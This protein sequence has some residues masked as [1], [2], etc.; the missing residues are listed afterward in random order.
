MKQ[1]RT[2][3]KELTAMYR[4]VLRHGIL[5]NAIA[6][7]LIATA[8]AMAE[9][10]NV[11][12][13]EL[14]PTGTAGSFKYTGNQNVTWLAENISVTEPGDGRAIE[15]GKNAVYSAT[16]PTLLHLGGDNTNTININTGGD[17]ILVRTKSVVDVRANDTISITSTVN[18][19]AYDG[20]VGYG[21]L[22]VQNSSDPGQT[23]TYATVNL[24][25]NQINL[26]NLNA[27]AIAALSEGRVNINGNAT[28]K[29]KDAI[30]ASGLSVT[31]INAAG[32]KTVK[33]DGDI[34]FRQGPNS[35]APVDATVNV[36]LNGAESYWTGNT[37]LSYEDKPSDDKLQINHGATIKMTDGATWTATEVAESAE[38]GVATNGR[39]YT[40]LKNLDVNSGNV[41]VNRANGIEVENL[42]VGAGGLTINSGDMTV[43]E[44]LKSTGRTNIASG[45]G[46]TVNATKGA[47]FKGSEFSGAGGAIFA[48]TGGSLDID[49]AKFENNT[50]TNGG[51]ITNLGTSELTIDNS[52]FTGNT[53]ATNGGAIQ[54]NATVDA[55]ISNTTFSGN[56]TGKSSTGGSGG[57]I[58]NG[59]G[60][61][62]LTNNTFTGNGK[63][64]DG[65]TET[66][67]TGTG[68][69]I[70][71][72]SG[73]LE[74]SGG[75][76]TD[77]MANKAGAIYVASGSLS[78]DGTEITGNA[79]TGGSGVIWVNG[80]NG[81]TINNATIDNN[82]GIKNDAPIYVVEG[83]GLVP[84][85][86]GATGN[87]G[88]IY[89]S[90]SGK[91][92]TITGGSISQN[93][94]A[95]GGAIY[96][97]KGTLNIDGTTF[98]GNVASGVSKT[99]SVIGGG[100]IRNLDTLNIKDATFT[101]NIAMEKGGAIF[102][103]ASKTITFD[104]SN[105][106][107]GNKSDVTWDEEN[108]NITAST[109]NDIYNNMGT[110]NIISGAGETNTF[111]GGFDGVA[112]SKLYI[113]GAGT[114]NI[115]NTLKKHTVDVN[116]GELHLTNADLTGSTI[117]VASGAI[118]N[119]IDDAIQDLS[120]NITLADGAGIKGDIDWNNGT[121]DKYASAAGTVK[122]YV[123]NLLNG[124]IGT[125]EKA[126]QV[127]SDGTTVDIAEAIFTSDTGVT[128]NSSGV[129]DGQMIVRGFA[130]GINTAVETTDADGAR[131]ALNYTVTENEVFDSDDSIDNSDFRITGTGADGFAIELQKD[132]NVSENA[133]LSLN[134]VKFTGSSDIVNKAGAT[135]NIKDSF[136][137]VNVN[138][139]GVLK[140][141][142]T[143]YAGTVNNVAGATAE[144]DNDTFGA[145]ATLANAGTVDLKNGVK[146]ASGASITGAGVMNLVSGTTVFNDTANTNN[147]FV[148]N[149]AGFSGSLIGGSLDTRNN[150]IDTG[151]GT[152]QNANLYVDA[153]L[154]GATPAIDSFAG[155]TGSTI[156]SI[157]LTSSEYGTA[158]SITLAVG[159]ATLSDDL[160]ITGAMNYYTKVEKDGTNLVFSDKLVNASGMKA[161]ARLA[162]YD[163]TTSGLTATTL[164]GAIDE[165][166][167]NVAAINTTLGTYGDVVTHD[168]AE[169]ASAA[170]G[171]KAD[172]AI[173]S[174][175]VNGT[176]LTPDAAKAVDITAVTGIKIGTG[177]AQ[178]G[179]VTLGTTA[180]TNLAAN[181]D[182]A[183]PTD[184]EIATWAADNA[185]NVAT[186]GTTF[187]VL[188]KKLMNVQSD[189]MA[190][191]DNASSIAHALGAATGVG[192]IDQV[193]A[194]AD[195]R[196]VA[197]TVD[198]ADL[199]TAILTIDGSSV[200]AKDKRNALGALL[201][202]GANAG[203]TLTAASTAEAVAEY[204][205]LSADVMS[206]YD[207]GWDLNTGLPHDLVAGKMKIDVLN[208]A[209]VTDKTV[210]GAINAN[211]A[212]IANIATT[213]TTAF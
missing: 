90:T 124:D 9:Y 179:E 167:T 120:S 40:A 101:N 72:N 25:A 126:F 18:D 86:T 112:G 138:N 2:V 6:L 47:S 147:V 134:D 121:A 135:L 119:T 82:S 159:D 209:S 93:V 129:A 87:G 58:Y 140:S 172:S 33:M 132:L 20:G 154:K 66:M 152:V 23:D 165:N 85:G 99:S 35:G 144:F 37:V 181:L 14:Y 175:K 60:K 131:L 71:N 28:I 26:T 110:I 114:T 44:S 191:G 211:T 21:A 200:E 75:S 36:T 46:L 128:F 8:P 127:V 163:N 102:N 1:T 15:I 55:E 61:L 202:T 54:N 50:A 57:A 123:G 145:T 11:S 19:P 83:L 65:N 98:N 79:S 45:A 201:T 151:L 22:W 139:F 146:F 197:S 182:A 69:A 118:I 208:D 91:T 107:S 17:G 24:T 34:D 4:A 116:S 166:A 193:N 125:G 164:Q 178:S 195:A 174:V 52:I 186:V 16:E 59:S 184:A 158:D 109:A 168:A 141:D 161:N 7:G 74:I 97:N 153:N 173:Q 177:A 84:A 88:A 80:G 96:N 180:A 198:A 48:A 94:A 212:A 117:N 213:A 67:K 199:H 30:Y 136:I 115:A 27:S 157:N 162:D 39:Y 89:N 92:S 68:G 49:Y 169:F 12:L 51:A 185:T 190:A 130:G 78:I 56:Y 188:S 32:D 206:Q 183:T 5:C 53:V 171:T 122:Y 133:M 205:K 63:L 170:Q 81:F 70:Y 155:T 43:S 62:T 105:T 207:F 137:G 187:D 108:G 149:G 31:N 143:T 113:N 13:D 194:M 95:T 192:L 100:A 111:A 204:M 76:I 160:Q 41:V 176:A 3:L 103:A 106:F 42:A 77:N 142:P 73:T 150:N 104:G 210:A 29:G 64:V 203:K 196:I 148:A 10:T 156:K 38:P 189:L